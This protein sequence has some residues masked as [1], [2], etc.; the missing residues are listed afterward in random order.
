MYLS[1]I[2]SIERW[3][4]FPTDSCY[5]KFL[6]RLAEYHAI[7]PEHFIQRLKFF[8][9][10]NNI[11]TQ[12]A[13]AYTHKINTTN[14]TPAV[15]TD[16]QQKAY[17]A[18]HTD[19]MSQQYHATLLHGVTGSGKTEIYKRIIIDTHNLNKTSLFMVPEVSLAVSFYLRL[20]KELSSTIPF[21]SFHSA[22]SDKEK[23]ELWHQLLMNTPVV[24][25]GVHLPLLLPISNLGLIIVD[26][27]HEV[28]YQE[29]K[30]PYINSKDAAIL[31]AHTAQIPI[32]L[33]SATPSLRSLYNVTH[34]NWHLI[35]LIPS[36]CRQ[37]P[38]Y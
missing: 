6:E 22:T 35:T 14:I 5:W 27:E 17:V 7:E 9:S 36:L 24:I 32:I 18:I 31:R 20:K 12:I 10:N 23:K 15:L 13:H 34:K 29:K 16:E 37:L 1:T 8:L 4:I 28:G 33:G 3:E 19:L 26:E 38:F 21:Y 25:I 30:H 2:K 11:K